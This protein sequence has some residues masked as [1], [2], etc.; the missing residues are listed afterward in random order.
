MAFTARRQRRQAR[1]Q[2]RRQARRQARINTRQQSPGVTFSGGDFEEGDDGVPTTQEVFDSFEG[3]GPAVAPPDLSGLFPDPSLVPDYK[4]KKNKAANFIFTD[5][6]AFA[7]KFADFNR[8]E[9]A[10]NYEQAKG[11]ALDQLNTELQGLQNFAPAASA[12][13]RQQTSIDNIFNQKQRTAQINKT[14]PG[15]RGQLTA[16]GKRAETYASGRLPDSI[17]DAALE[18]GIRSR[19]A[20]QATAGGFGASSSVS[21]KASDLMS[22]EERLQIANYGEQLLTSNIGTKANLLLAPT[23]YSDAGQQIRVTPEVGAGRLSS[24]ALSEINQASLIPPGAALNAVIQQREFR[25]QL[26]QR[27]KEF[28]R[29]KKLNVQSLNAQ[30]RNQFALQKFGY[31]VAHAGAEAG[32]ATANNNIALGIAQQAQYAD[33]FSGALAQSQSAAQTASIASGIG[34]IITAGAGL[35]SGISSL[36]GGGSGTSA[37]SSGQAQLPGGQAQAPIEA[38]Q[39]GLPEGGVA[40]DVSIPGGIQFPDQESIAPGFTGITSNPNG[41]VTAIPTETFNGSVQPFSRD[42]NLPL[43]QGTSPGTQSLIQGSNIALQNAG[44][45]YMPSDINQPIGFSPAGQRVYSDR[46]LLQSEDSQQGSRYVDT[47]KEIIDPTG[48]LTEDDRSTLDQVS[49]IAGDASIIATL[50]S[51]HQNGD[52]KGFVNTV[53]SAVKQ[54]VIENLSKDPQNQAG[55]QAAFNAYQ[56]F[57]NW[58]R[59]SPAQKGLALAATGLQATKFADGTNLATKNIIDTT[60]AADGKTVVSPGLNV[61]QALQLFQ[62]G[63]NV[64]TMV[65][66]WDQLNNLQKAAYGTSSVAQTAEM[67]RRFGMLG[68]GTA[69]AEVTITAAEL[70]AAGYTS[71]PAYGVGAAV[72]PSSAAVPEG[73]VTVANIGEQAVIAPAGTASSASGAVSSN[74]GSTVGTAAQTPTAPIGTLQ[75]VAGAA[76]IAAGAYQI[77]QGWGTGGGKGATN[78]ALG[79]SAVAAGLHT[80]GYSNPYLLAA[81]VATSALTGLIKTG[82]HKDQVARDG[83]RGNLQKRGFIDKQYNV[84]LADGSLVNIGVDGK[85]GLHGITDS[86][87]LSEDHKKNGF[88]RGG[89]LHA[90]DVDYTNDL[91][92]TANMGTGTLMR[93]LSGGKQDASDKIGGQLA[94]AAVSQVGFNQEMTESNFNK[95]IDNVRSF[96]VQAGITSKADAYQ[97]ANM[98]YAEGRLNQTDL[99]TAHQSINVVFDEDGYEQAQ[100]L[101]GGRDRGADIAADN[102]AAGVEDKKPKS[103]EFPEPSRIPEADFRSDANIVEASNQDFRQGPLILGNNTGRPPIEEDLQTTQLDKDQVLQLN[104]ERYGNNGQVGLAA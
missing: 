81:V 98:A 99:V 15:V 23:E 44:I 29:S 96:Y 68:S 32:A 19:A 90:Y 35:I 70:G 25:T 82:K 7:E 63:Y 45:S 49:A 28:N 74:A 22:A 27:N 62:A 84:S 66:N 48:A 102:V 34:E 60:F 46:A 42:L 1:K 85:G 80:L 54:P 12:L 72:G 20:D 104:R 52:K 50:T 30:I 10:K 14:L 86:N 94:N 79:G 87:R 88:G 56:I 100:Q 57:S 64:Y 8:S 41:T 77:Y 71:T 61:G 58:D 31:Q 91:D 93:L 18:L 24:Q 38:P 83:V 76:A 95:T 3:G 2:A 103:P 33:I 4:N 65:D 5:P 73:Y 51:Q 43:G 16:Q 13:K 39:L 40:S 37:P 6:L 53:L 17:Q 11:L 75:T 47:L 97:L 101:M 78:G 69:G 55:M 67:A 36:A 9:I 59:M 21:R 92:Y 89:Q 26:R